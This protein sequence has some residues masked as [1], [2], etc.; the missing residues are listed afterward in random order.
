[1]TYESKD[2]QWFALSSSG[3]LWPL[4]DCG[5]FDAA[6][7]IANDLE[8]DVIWIVDSDTARQWLN[9]INVAMER[10]TT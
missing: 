9:T 6:E 2:R 1:M 3:F 10:I 5:D 4:G 8:L 7:E